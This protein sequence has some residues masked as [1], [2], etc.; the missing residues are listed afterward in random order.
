MKNSHKIAVSGIGT[1]LSVVFMF[2]GGIL[3]VFSYAVPV[4]LGLLMMMINK[5][6]GKKHALIVFL[7]VSF[8]SLIIVPDKESVLLYVMFF[9]YYPI[10]KPKLDLIKLK[11]LK[12]ICKAIMFN[13]AVFTA[14]LFAFYLFGIPFFEGEMSTVIFALLFAAAMNT[15]FIMYDFMLNRFYVLYVKKLESKI[16]KVFK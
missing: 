7:S 13:A 5:T 12:I 16:K 11:L 14:E 4:L 1:A 10:I 8:L 2:L 6:L 15:I 3:Y 9:G